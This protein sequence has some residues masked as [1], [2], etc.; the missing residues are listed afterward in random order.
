MDGQKLKNYEEK[1]Y[2]RIQEEEGIGLD[3]D[4]TSLFTRMD[5]LSKY[6]TCAV[7]S[8]EESYGYLP[9]D[10]VRDKDGNA[11]ALAI[12]E[13]FAYIESLGS[14]PL[15]FLDGLYQKYG[16]HLEKTENIYY[17]G[18]QGNATIKR[19]I[20]SYRTDP[21][22]EI[23]DLKV[24]STKDYTEPVYVDED[25]EPIVTQNFL[26][27][28]LDNHFRIDIRPSGT[29]PKIKY[30]LFGCGEAKPVNLDASKKE[31]HEMLD[32]VAKWILTDAEERS[33]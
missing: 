16:Y 19:L 1:A 28:F 29:E 9:L 14:T 18:A 4:N 21:I 25:E 27:L 10:I 31:V 24:E 17:E 7:L 22:T 6:S 26:Q 15:N 3:F 32:K 30:Y 33:K 11:S 23:L 8:A 20:E 5:I 2:I 13:A 12:A